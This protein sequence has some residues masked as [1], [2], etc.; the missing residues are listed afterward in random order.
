VKQSTVTAVLKDDFDVLGRKCYTFFSID[1]PLL[2][3]KHKVLPKLTVI[4]TQAIQSTNLLCWKRLKLTYPKMNKR[5]ALFFSKARC[6][7]EIIL[8][9][10]FFDH[11]YAKRCEFELKFT[12]PKSGRY[13]CIDCQI[14]NHEPIK[15]L[16]PRELSYP[17]RKIR[18]QVICKV[19]KW[20]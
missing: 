13:W 17:R 2:K 18:T 5:N 14:S 3:G 1:H 12:T 11:M 15:R 8:S 16:S 9:W 7:Q 19:Q 6:H 20:S 10:M 4:R